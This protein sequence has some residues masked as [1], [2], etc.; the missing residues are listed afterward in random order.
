V[1]D[2]V[3]ADRLTMDDLN[4]LKAIVQSDRENGVR[5]L[6]ADRIALCQAEQLARIAAALERMEKKQPQ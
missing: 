1:L 6:L 2:F 3:Y 5:V 4:E